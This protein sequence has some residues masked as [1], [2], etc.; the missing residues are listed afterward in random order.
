MKFL[1]GAGARN[2]GL[3]NID[4][5][6]NSYDVLAIQRRNDC[7]TCGQGKFEFLEGQRGATMTASLCGRNAIQVNPGRGHALKLD[8]L[9]ARLHGIGQVVVNEYLVRANIDNFEITIFPDARAIIKGT[10]DATVARSVYA[11]YVG[12]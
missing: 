3:I 7:P 6:E 12:S 11:K 5:W 9:A 4:V 1:A 2:P 8:E 10:D